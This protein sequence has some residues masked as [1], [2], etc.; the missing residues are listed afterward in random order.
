MA[1]PSLPYVAEDGR[2]VVQH[3]SPAEMNAQARDKAR[4]AYG[5]EVRVVDRAVRELM[6][7]LDQHGALEDALVVLVGTQGEE[8]FE[9]GGWGHGDT[10]YDEQ[11][12]TPLIMK[13]PG[14]RLAG[15]Q[16]PWQVS[17]IDIAPTILAVTGTAQP[18]P[19]EGQS[20]LDPDTLAWLADPESPQPKAR[21]AVAQLHR[22]GVVM[23]AYRAP[24]WKLVRARS[25]S[26]RGVPTRAI[27]NLE[28]DPAERVNLAGQ[29]GAREPQLSRELRE[30]LARSMS[31]RTLPVVA[32]P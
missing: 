7:W 26:T 28:S 8:L 19:W 30:R 15:R 22:H 2:A 13:L 25:G 3:R 9:H 17:T 21:P 14:G 6:D 11:L 24:P 10:V 12:R 27:F 18:E 23:E 31:W 1:E 4:L 16:V 20:L 32:R 5:A 29:T